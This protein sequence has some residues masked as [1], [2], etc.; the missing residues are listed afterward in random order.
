ME[1]DDDNFLDGVIEFGDGRQYKIESSESQQ[2]GLSKEAPSKSGDSTYGPVAKEERFVDD[3]DRSWPKSRTSP[4]SV[5]RDVGSTTSASH[6]VT[7]T[8]VSPVVSHAAHSPQDS[9]RVLFNERSNRLEPY[10]QA[11][12]P[13]NAPFSAKRPG[14]PDVPHADMKGSAQNIQVLQKPAGADLSRSRRFSNVSNSGGSY[15]GG[16]VNGYTGD[17][18]RDPH[19]RDGPPAS[20]RLPR[21]LPPHVQDNRDLDRGRRVPNGMGPPPLPP[22]VAQG[23]RQLPPHLSQSPTALPSPRLPSRDSRRVPPEPPQS[24]TS[25]PSAHIPA[26]SPAVSHKSL[27]SPAVVDKALPP[28]AVPD[29]DVARK[30]V[31]HSAAERAKQRRLEEEAEREAQ[32]DRARKKAA[33]LE[34]RMKAIEAEKEKARQREKEAAAEAARIVQVSSCDVFVYSHD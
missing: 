32:K 13:N 25:P 22:H 9:S 26:Q 4:A 2:T 21:D 12:R 27:V 11:H 18:N 10:S 24:A 19:R 29:L 5:S 28:L 20:P 34:E 6:S 31:M 16:S 23:G 33:E 14:F 3:F 30:D 1:E 15:A 7:P 17:R 8:N